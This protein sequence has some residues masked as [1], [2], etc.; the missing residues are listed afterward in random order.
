LKALVSID[1]FV[2]DAVRKNPS[3]MGEVVVGWLTCIAFVDATDSPRSK[4]ATFSNVAYRRLAR[5][6]RALAKTSENERFHSELDYLQSEFKSWV[7]KSPDQIKQRYSE[8]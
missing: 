7:N 8:A 3:L 5:L 2:L 1:R 6:G 4:T